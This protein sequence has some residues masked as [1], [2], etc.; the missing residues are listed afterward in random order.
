MLLIADSGS[1]KTTWVVAAKNEV[2]Q[3]FETGGLNPNILT[4]DEID[5]QLEAEVVPQLLHRHY[6][7]AVQ[8]VIFYGASF[9]TDTYCRRM[10]DLLSHVLGLEEA[11]VHHDILGAARAAAQDEPALVCIMGTGSNSCYYDGQQMVEQIGGHGYLFGDEGGGVDLGKRLMQCMLN[12]QASP[13]LKDRFAAQ[14][15]ADLLKV[16]NHIYSA[17]KINAELAAMTP[18]VQQCLDLPEVDAFV[19]QSFRDF[20]RLTLLQHIG[21]LHLPV[22]FV[23]SVGTHFR[24]QVEAVCLAEGLQPGRYLARPAEDLVIFHQRHDL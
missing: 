16:R 18:F 21:R 20:V 3:T 17:N 9:S 13:E 23:G 19:Q 12:R 22:H 11:Q 8:Q 2:L 24:P 4:F 10:E 6:W 14:Y 7:G 1:S 15:G 5:S